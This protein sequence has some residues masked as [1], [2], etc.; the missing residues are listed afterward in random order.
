[1]VKKWPLLNSKDRGIKLDEFLADI[2]GI[3][4]A[5]VALKDALFTRVNE[6]KTKKIGEGVEFNDDFVASVDDLAQ[7]LLDRG[8]LTQQ[9]RVHVNEVIGR[10]ISDSMLKHAKPNAP[11]KMS[12]AQRVAASAVSMAL[13]RGSGQNSL[14]MANAVRRFILDLTPYAGKETATVRTEMDRMLADPKAF[15][16][17]VKFP[18]GKMTQPQADNFIAKLFKGS[19]IEA[20][21]ATARRTAV[22]AAQTDKDREE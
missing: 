11:S 17:G 15:L 2:E 8:I 18:K 7:E 12:Q 4:G 20:F 3:D 6:L 19:R 5:E 21:D 1:M 9:D 14:I 10:V 22:R 16:D 13:L